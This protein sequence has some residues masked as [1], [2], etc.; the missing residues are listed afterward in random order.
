MNDAGRRGTSACTGGGGPWA[1]RQAGAAAARRHRSVL[2]PCGAAA[3]GLNDEVRLAVEPERRSPCSRRATPA[4]RVGGVG[5]DQRR[6]RRRACGTNVTDVEAVDLPLDAVAAVDRD[7]PA[8]VLVRVA[9]RLLELLAA[10]RE[11]AGLHRL[12]R[13]RAT[14]GTREQRPPRSIARCR[15]TSV[16]HF[17]LRGVG[18]RPTLSPAS[19]V[20]GDRRSGRAASME[21]TTLGPFTVSRLCLGTML[22]GAKTPRRRVAPDAGPL[23]RGRR[24]RSSTPP[25]RTPTA[26]RR[27]RSRRGSRDHRDEVVLATKV[28]FA[29]SDPGGAGA[30]A[31]SGS[32][33][34][35]TRACGGSAP[36]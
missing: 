28:R 30:R 14:A 10:L 1:E 35:A 26:A 33:R 23:P 25:T 8:E 5:D 31:A 11:G 4:D 20:R 2:P 16:H 34:P 7:R 22:M 27:R 3:S 15:N 24:Q 9:E 21:T 29:V 12:G 13:R 32:S 17:P 36:T 6:R 18:V 19:P